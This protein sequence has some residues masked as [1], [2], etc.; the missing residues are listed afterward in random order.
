GDFVIRPRL[1]AFQIDGRTTTRGVD[2]QHRP[3]A[4]EHLFA[5]EIDFFSVGIGAAEKKDRRPLAFLCFCWMAKVTVV[6][7]VSRSHR[8]HFDLSI[9]ELSGFAEEL[10]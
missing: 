2:E 10:L 4:I 1:D 5:A 8:Y 3:A 7:L 9:V 6:L